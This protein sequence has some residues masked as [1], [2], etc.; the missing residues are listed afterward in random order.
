MTPWNTCVICRKHWPEGES[1]PCH[2]T[3]EEWA[4][5]Q[6]NLSLPEDSNRKARRKARSLERVRP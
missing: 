3:S 1:P 6:R 4:E 2:H 5:Y